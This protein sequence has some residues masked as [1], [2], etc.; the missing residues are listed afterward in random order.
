MAPGTVEIAIVVGLF[1]ILF[2][3]TQLPKL[4]RSLGQAKTE[5]NRGLTEGGGES[6]TEADM[7][8]GGRTEN[9]ALAE[10]AASKGIDVEGK[11]IDEVKEEVQSS[12]EE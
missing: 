1:F 5:F 4:A 11:T 2:G 8:R 6:T 10:D 3:P 9:V 7:D 12:E